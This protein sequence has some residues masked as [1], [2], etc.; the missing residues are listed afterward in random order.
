MKTIRYLFY[1]MLLLSNIE[2]QGGDFSINAFLDYLQEKG[3]YEVLQAIKIYYGDDIA[4]AVCN[5]LT[6]SNDCITVVR[7]YMTPDIGGNGSSHIPIHI[8][9]ES[10]DKIFKAI[11]Q[12]YDDKLF[13]NLEN[14]ILL[15]LSYYYTLI[16]G[17]SDRE[18]YEFIVAIIENKE[19]RKKLLFSE[20]T[21]GKIVID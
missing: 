19:I 12:K 4:I 17:M 6:Q 5:E 16:E 21:K 1:M 13:D 8:N 15:I 10:D 2:V 20:K 14:L 3:Y 9:P 7:I 11:K 18:I